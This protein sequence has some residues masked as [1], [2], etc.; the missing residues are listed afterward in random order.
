M[1]IA[2][3]NYVK[4]DIE[5]TVQIVALM[6]CFNSSVYLP[7]FHTD[8]GFH[9]FSSWTVSSSYISRTNLCLYI[10]LHGATFVFK[11][12][13]TYHFKDVLTR[14]AKH[15]GIELKFEG[16]VAMYLS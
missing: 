10:P 14:F 11:D 12:A 9:H 5:I 2:D 1:S 15:K 7:P 4:T 6:C 8:K 3:L 16:C 13:L